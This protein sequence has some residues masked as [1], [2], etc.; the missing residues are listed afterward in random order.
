VITLTSFRAKKKMMWYFVGSFHRIDM[1]RRRRELGG[2]VCRCGFVIVWARSSYDVACNWLGTSS[3][4]LLQRRFQVQ[5]FGNGW[6]CVV[7]VADLHVLTSHCTFL[8]PSPSG[9]ISGA[10]PVS[11]LNIG[12][13]DGPTRPQRLPEPVH[14]GGCLRIEEGMDCNAVGASPPS[15]RF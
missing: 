8:T 6:F 7:V 15:R 4:V 9:G 5:N 14:E 10:R 13:R 2:I 1:W 12:M 11:L 3:I